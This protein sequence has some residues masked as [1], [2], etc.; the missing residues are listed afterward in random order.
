MLKSFMILLGIVT[1][2]NSVEPEPLAH[3]VGAW[4]PDSRTRKI[5]AL[6][7]VASCSGIPTQIVVALV[8]GAIGVSAI[9]D[10]GGLSFVYIFALSLI[11]TVLVVGLIS[12]FLY[13]RRESITNLIFGNRSPNQEA[14]FGMKLIPVI[15]VSVITGAAIISWLA[16]SLRNVPDN[17]LESLLDTPI[18]VALFLVVV[19]V[20]GGFREELQRAFV[21]KRFDQHLGG[22][23]LGL[24]IFSIAFGLGHQIQGWDAAILTGALGAFWGS[25]YLI[26]RSA[27]APIVS[28]SGFNAA[29]ILLALLATNNP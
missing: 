29:Q 11:D 3:P 6:V 22:G 20:A 16:P 13:S 25:I 17:P 26:R 15:L 19:I 9:N 4:P 28:H 1:E 10:S 21:L 12:F 5:H 8:L 18:H 14:L 2:P 23:W 7:E 27:I 24:V